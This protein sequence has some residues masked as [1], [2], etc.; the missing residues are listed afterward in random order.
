MGFTWEFPQIP[1][2]TAILTQLH[3]VLYFIDVDHLCAHSNLFVYVQNIIDKQRK[4]E[5]VEK[6]YLIYHRT[7]D[8]NNCCEMKK[9]KLFQEYTKKFLL[10]YA[11]NLITPELEGWKNLEVINTRMCTDKKITVNIG[12]ESGFPT[13]ALI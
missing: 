1:I 13:D 8:K 12:I 11:A 7:F 4:I 9:L 6:L 3:Q 2:P 10:N 5:L